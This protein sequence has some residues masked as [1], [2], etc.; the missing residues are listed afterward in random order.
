MS[1]TYFSGNQDKIKAGIHKDL[2]MFQG[3]ETFRSDL[4]LRK[5][6][7]CANAKKRGNEGC[8]GCI[9]LY[10]NFVEKK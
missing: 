4:C 2:S 6:R 9:P 7:R 5:E 10:H 8:K 1:E 3:K